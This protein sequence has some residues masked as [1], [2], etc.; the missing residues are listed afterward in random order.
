MA[1]ALLGLP[2]PCE[3]ARFPEDSLKL[4]PTCVFVHGHDHLAEDLSLPV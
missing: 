1:V 4:R 2:V 3:S